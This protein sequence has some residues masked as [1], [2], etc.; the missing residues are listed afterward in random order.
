MTDRPPNE[1][2]NVD[3]I[4]VETNYTVTIM[5]GDSLALALDVTRK[6][7]FIDAE[8]KCR[9]QGAR[10]VG[11]KSEEIKQTLINDH[12]GRM[13]HKVKSVWDALIDRRKPPSDAAPP[14]AIA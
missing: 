10:L 3:R 8:K 1:L 2:P 4:T 7:G 12:D 9:E 14:N 6:R 5:P 13:T 11:R